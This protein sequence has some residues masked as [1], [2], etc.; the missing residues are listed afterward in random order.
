[1][2]NIIDYS[3]GFTDGVEKGKPIFLEKL[4]STTSDF[5]NMYIDSAAKSNPQ[6]LH[7]VYEWYQSGNPDSRLFEIK[8]NIKGGNILFTSQFKQSQSIAN[9]AREPFYDK[10]NIMENG[11]NL[12][13]APKNAQV[14]AFQINGED[15]FTPNPVTIKN[16]GGRVQGE[17]ENIFDQFF[18]RYFSQSFLQ[19]S[20]L[21][22][23]LETP[24]EFSKK[25]SSGAKQ[26]KSAGISA[27]YTW[28][29]NAK[30]GVE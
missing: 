9:G 10:A 4:A 21:I 12:R 26:G 7:H 23:H 11:G 20:G 17:F 22:K 25:L 2:N 1:M 13:I 3:I 28:V 19:S 24:S 18:S 16:P 27:G 30:V 8:F 6:F 14:L 5:L 29:T 15:V